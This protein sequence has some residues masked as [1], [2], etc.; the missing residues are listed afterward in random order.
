MKKGILA[1]A[2]LLMAGVLPLGNLPLHAQSDFPRAQLFGG[3]SYVSV[4][5]GP[6]NSRKGLNGWNGQGTV[7]LNRWFGLTADF[8]GYYGS[9]FNISVHDYT[10]MGGPTLTYRAEH[11]APF[12][13]ALVGADHFGVSNVPGAGS[14]TKFAWAVGGGIDIPITRQ[15]GIRLVQADFL[16]TMHGGDEQNN[17]RLS[18]GL[19]FMFGG[20]PAG[21]GERQLFSF[22]ERGYR[23]RADHGYGY[24]Q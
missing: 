19:D 11:V 23:R 10:F 18:T 4:D 5:T 3:Y 14:N 13:H 8:G 2:T 22:A 7:N 24:R 1:F 6:N 20:A 21:S 12:L 15:F 17:I 16:R 9:P